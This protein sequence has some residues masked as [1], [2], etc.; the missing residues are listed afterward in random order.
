MDP[1]RAPRTV[2]D[3]KVRQVGFFTP[4]QSQSL[5]TAPDESGSPSPPSDSPSPVMIPPPRH[6]SAPV[7]VPPPSSPLRRDGLTVFPVGSY[8]PA[9]YLIGTS[10]SPSPQSRN[11]GSEF[12]EDVSWGRVA[13]SFP[14]SGGEM[15][16]TTSAAN[17]LQ[18]KSSLT[19]VSVVKLPS[20]LTGNCAID[21]CF[22]LLSRM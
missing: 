13:S 11:G 1:R 10:P 16:A 19:T 2:I 21:T 20:G 4:P 5:A 8:N 15:M 22:V 3:P 18:P 12:S 7:S 17:N 6:L 9:E 14:G